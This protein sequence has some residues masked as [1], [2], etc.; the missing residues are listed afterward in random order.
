M[1]KELNNLLKQAYYR[2]KDEKDPPI[3]PNDIKK[4]L[5]I[6]GIDLED[7]NKIDVRK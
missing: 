2:Y 3:D 4:F 6:N 1:C 5:L 7:E